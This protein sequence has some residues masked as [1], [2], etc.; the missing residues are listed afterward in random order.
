MLDV[1]YSSQFKKDVRT[2]EKRGYNLSLLQQA[3]DTL[4]IPANL[5]PQNRNHPLAGNY[6]GYLECHLARIGC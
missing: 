3:L 4:R 2:C 5:P 6:A 1:R